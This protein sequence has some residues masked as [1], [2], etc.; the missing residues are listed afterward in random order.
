MPPKRNNTNL[1]S[2]EASRKR[3]NDKQNV[4]KAKAAA[5][6]EEQIKLEETKRVA[7]EARAICGTE[8]PKKKKKWGSRSESASSKISGD[9]PKTF[10]YRIKSCN[11]VF[12]DIGGWADKLARD[13]VF[14]ARARA[15]T[16]TQ[17]FMD[18]TG[19]E[20]CFKAYLTDGHEEAAQLMV[21][22]RLH[23]CLVSF[24]HRGD[25]NPLTTKED[26]LDW[27]GDELKSSLLQYTSLK[28]KEFPQWGGYKELDAVGQIMNVEDTISVICKFYDKKAGIYCKASQ[29]N[30]YQFWRRGHLPMDAY[31][32]LKLSPENIDPADR[33]RLAL[34]TKIAASSAKETKNTAVTQ[35]SDNGSDGEDE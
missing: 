31:K 16:E 8:P 28:E 6:R 14:T 22:G 20:Y 2:A 4:N 12:I 32:R 18:E 24:M 19:L 7:S 13:H 15:S 30:L 21:G 5:D 23:R 9:K 29:D 35:D 33:E 10:V 26:W 3:Q 27:H 34:D 11:H 1:T 17:A 25:D